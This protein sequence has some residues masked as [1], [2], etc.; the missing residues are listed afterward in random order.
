MRQGEASAIHVQEPLL[1]V[2]WESGMRSVDGASNQLGTAGDAV[3]AHRVHDSHRVEKFLMVHRKDGLNVLFR[4]AKQTLLDVW[5]KDH[6]GI[7]GIIAVMHTFGKDLKWNPHMHC[8]VTCGGLDGQQWRWMRFVSYGRLAVVW[9][10]H[11]VNGVRELGKKQWKGAQY[12]KFNR[13]LNMLYQK[14]WYVNV[15]KR[16]D[17][18]EF[19]VKY[20]GRYAKRPVIAETRLKSFDGETVSF[21]YKDGGLQKEVVLQIP[22]LE[23]IGKLVRHIPEKHHRMI[24]YSGLFASRV[25][26]KMLGLVHAALKDGA[27]P[28]HTPKKIRS[29]RDR[30]IDWSHVDPHQCTCGKTMRLVELVIALRNGEWKRVTMPP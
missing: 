28:I 8:I 12:T 4:A 1:L 24:R 23:F 7:P 29:W 9:R 25:K 22:V 14:K 17:S 6:K 15:G 20:I 16:L 18:L 11:V 10:Y 30:I 3:S 27:L 5:M 2:V 26:Q 13:W 21:A 19:T